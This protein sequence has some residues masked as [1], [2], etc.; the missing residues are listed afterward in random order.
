M[1]L[2]GPGRYIDPAATVSAIRAAR[3]RTRLFTKLE[4]QVL[5]YYERETVPMCLQHH[6]SWSI[7]VL[8]ALV[9]EFADVVVYV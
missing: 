6:V 9:E 8:R 3:P 5:E 4:K 1:P 2:T 7:T